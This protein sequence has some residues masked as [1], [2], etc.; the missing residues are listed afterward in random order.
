VLLTGH[1]IIQLSYFPRIGFFQFDQMASWLNDLAPVAAVSSLCLSTQSY[2]SVSF[3]LVLPSNI[4]VIHAH[5]HIYI[6]N[7]YITF[8]QI[9][10]HTHTDKNTYVCVYIYISCVCVCVCVCVS[11]CLSACMSVYISVYTLSH[12]NSYIPN[13]LKY[14]HAHYPNLTQESTTICVTFFIVSF[15]EKHSSLF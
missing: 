5:T 9:H 14:T 7:L 1:P 11:A 8:T 10:A 3:L 13:N 15:C 2:I 6:Y 4:R 12:S